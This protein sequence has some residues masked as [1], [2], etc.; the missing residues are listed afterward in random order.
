VQLLLTGFAPFGGEHLN[1]SWEVACAI[2]DAPVDG[3]TLSVAEL[4]IQARVAF[5]ALRPLWQSRRFD[6]W[7]GLGQAG[8]RAQICVERVALNLLHAGS[9]SAEGSAASEPLG[10]DAE[11]ALIDGAPGAYLSTLD[12]R[13]LGAAIRAAGAPA[14]LSYSAGTFLCNQVLYVMEHDLRQ[15]ADGERAVF[16]HLPYLP[17]QLDRKPFDT[18]SLALDVQVK[19]VR[20]AIE[21]LRDQRL[22]SAAG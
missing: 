18:P 4:P 9:L 5:D 2:R 19:G 22:G 12:A 6:V 20:A 21:W 3:V 15:R 11:E 8:Q 10:P 7:L 13:A 1:P 14:A 16:L 17:E